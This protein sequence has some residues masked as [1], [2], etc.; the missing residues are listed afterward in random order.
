MQLSFYETLAIVSSAFALWFAVTRASHVP[1]PRWR[2]PAAV[3]GAAILVF[4]IL[5]TTEFLLG[6][7][8]AVAGA[9]EATTLA[10]FDAV[11]D[12]AYRPMIIAVLGLASFVAV[13]RSASLGDE[14]TG[15]RADD[16]GAA[17]VLLAATASIVGLTT[18]HVGL[19]LDLEG[20]FTVAWMRHTLHLG[21][22]TM[23]LCALGGAWSTYQA[24]A[25]VPSEPSQPART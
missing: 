17:L 15:S 25:D 9:S 21:I 5:G 7:L 19:I 1:R 24:F 22:G 11:L 12:Y 10:A 20:A 6:G 18:Y 16:A 3:F 2:L 4:G 13:L 8:N 14:G 23:I